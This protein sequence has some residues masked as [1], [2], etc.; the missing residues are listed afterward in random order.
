MYLTSKALTYG[1][2]F[3]FLGPQQTR[4]LDSISI[5]PFY[6]KEAKEISNFHVAFCLYFKSSPYS[7]QN[8]S[9]KK[10]R[11][12]CMRENA[13]VKCVLI[14]MVFRKALF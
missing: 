10:E 12:I 9:Y 4:E 8:F 3:Y 11:V 7:M 5:Q 14:F 13:Q 6:T 2:Q 1:K